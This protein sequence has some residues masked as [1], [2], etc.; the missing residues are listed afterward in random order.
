[1]YLNIHQ[2]FVKLNGKQTIKT[3]GF[4][5]QAAE[6]ITE[7]VVESVLRNVNTRVVVFSTG[8]HEISGR[9]SGESCGICPK[10]KLSCLNFY[11]NFF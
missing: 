7:N 9:A 2:R 1:M 3:M 10:G 6:K 5:L 11:I 8:N 4:Y